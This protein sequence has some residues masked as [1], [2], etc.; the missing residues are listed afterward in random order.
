VAPCEAGLL[1]ASAALHAMKVA[2]VRKKGGG[3]SG[4]GAAFDSDEEQPASDRG[5][6]SSRAAVNERVRLA[7][8][9]TEARVAEAAAVYRELSEPPGV[10]VDASARSAAAAG[11]GQSKYIAQLLE[12]A[13]SRQLA[14]ERAQDRARREQL[15]AEEAELGAPTQAFVTGAY[16]ARLAE[17][18][19]AEEEQDARDA[20]DAADAKGGL[21]SFYQGVL[22]AGLGA[23]E[24]DAQ[25]VEPAS[26][27]ERVALNPR[28]P[29]PPQP[30][31]LH[32]PQPQTRAQPQPPQHRASRQE[33]HA[34]GE[35]SQELLPA[36]RVNES[37]L[38]AARQRAL[39][40]IARRARDGV[41][42]V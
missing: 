12:T 14:T 27:P 9:A 16:Q 38:E 2:T 36:P 30:Q 17:R 41:L 26:I 3:G 6:G 31:L 11:P 19:R 25:V 40:R 32:P 34:A 21:Q 18:R 5:G 33:F 15:A 37:E 1:V 8:L 20:R 42:F 22:M 10:G 23:T 28:P 4:A 24:P 39:E 13:R 35:S 7:N 29:E